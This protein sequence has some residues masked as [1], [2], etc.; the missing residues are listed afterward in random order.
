MYKLNIFELD[1]FLRIFIKEIDCDGISCEIFEQCGIVFNI[2]SFGLIV[3][4][5]F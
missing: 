2:I 5:L 4:V 1:V 3:T